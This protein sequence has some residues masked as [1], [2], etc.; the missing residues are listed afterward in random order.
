[1]HKP[2]QGLTAGFKRKTLHQVLQHTISSASQAASDSEVQVLAHEDQAPHAAISKRLKA[3]QQQAVKVPADRLPDLQGTTAAAA[4]AATSQPCN[5]DTVMLQ[6]AEADAP[7]SRQEDEQLDIMMTDQQ[8]IPAEAGDTASTDAHLP[9]T[10]IITSQA[11]AQQQAGGDQMTSQQLNLPADAKQAA[12]QQQQQQEAARPAL[13]A[14]PA[15]QPAAAEPGII[16]QRLPSILQQHL[17]ASSLDD[18]SINIAA[19]TGGSLPAGLA[20]AGH[21]LLGLQ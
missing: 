10:G 8:Q 5:S 6:Q 11:T 17:T 2:G 12:A 1:M 7:F 14:E 16:T 9:T 15:P 3:N 20:A 21:V 4:S 18:D 19:L 13:L